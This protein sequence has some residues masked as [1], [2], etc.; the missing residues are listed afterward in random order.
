MSGLG[1]GFVL[2]AAFTGGAAF[3]FGVVALLARWVSR[4]PARLLRLAAR[5][6]APGFAK[7]PA[8]RP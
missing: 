8:G 7:R 4:D 5:G 1:L 6:K 2:V 3:A